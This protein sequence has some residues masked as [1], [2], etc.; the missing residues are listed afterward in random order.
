MAFKMMGGKSP[1][2]K[3]GNGVP[4]S[5]MGGPK[6]KSCGGPMMHEGN[7]KKHP[8]DKDKKPRPVKASVNSTTESLGRGAR[9]TTIKTTSEFGKAKGKD[10]GPGYKPSK[11]ETA[12]AN[13]QK[14][15]KKESKTIVRTS[16]GVKDVASFAPSTK[17]ERKKQ[18]A[19]TFTKKE[20]VDITKKTGDYKTRNELKKKIRKEFPT[21]PTSPKVVKKMAKKRKV[22]KVLNNISNVFRSKGGSNGGSK[23]GCLTD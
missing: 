13:K 11:A 10:L 14:K 23:P 4:S 8:K 19:K 3:T 1:K 2:A 20:L 22:K 18:P 5:L 12:K 15:L 17:L 16:K 7:G 9:R 21:K 6:M